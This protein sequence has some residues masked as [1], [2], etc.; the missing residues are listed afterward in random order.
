MNE[1]FGGVLSSL[2]GDNVVG[3]IAEKLQL[4]KGVAQSALSAAIPALLK[5]ITD[6]TTTGDGESSL[7]SALEG[8]HDG[9]ILN[10]I[11][12]YMKNPDMEDGGKILNHVLKGDTSNVIKRITE[13][14]GVSSNSAGSLLK[15]IAPLVMGF[16]G[17]QNSNSSLGIGSLLQGAMGQ[18]A[19]AGSD[20]DDDQSMLEKLLDRD[21]DGSTMD[22]ITKMGGDLLGKLF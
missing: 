7:R 2:M 4:D 19:S 13:K 5:K 14:S 12:S 18:L 9:S 17:K 10:N 15:M 21:N 22:D 16:L 6:N 8:K 11:S 20:N 3:G 1:L